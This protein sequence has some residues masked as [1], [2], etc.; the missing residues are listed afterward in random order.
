M[1]TGRT[2]A[3][4]LS[5]AT[6]YTIR[7]PQGEAWRPELAY[8]FM[9][10]MAQ[11]GRMLFRI[12]ADYSAIRFQIV[13]VREDASDDMVK[14]AVLATYPQAEVEAEPLA[15][16]PFVKPFHRWIVLF[17]QGV[18][19]VAPIRYPVELKDYDPLVSLTNL[20]GELQPDEYVSYLCYVGKHDPKLRDEAKKILERPDWQIWATGM[21]GAAFDMN[22]WMPKERFTPELQKIFYRKLNDVLYPTY[23]IAQIDTPSYER[24]LSLGSGIEN[25]LYEMS[26]ELQGIVFYDTDQ[27]THEINSEAD[28][29]RHSALSLLLAWSQGTN[30]LYKHVRCVFNVSEL[31]TLWHLPHEDFI[32]PTIARIS[33]RRVRIPAILRDKREGICL[34]D[35]VYAGTN[36]PVYMR[37]EDRSTHMIVVGR[38]GVG[39]STFL[40]NLIEQDIAAGSGVAVLDPHGDLIRDILHCSIPENRMDDVVLWDLADMQN[41]PPLNLLAIPKGV[42]RDK[43][44][45]QVMA[46]FEKVEEG[47][48]ATRM[49]ADLSM[50]LELLMAEPNPTLRDVRKVFVDEQYRAKLMEELENDIA[51]EFWEDFDNLS[52]R[53]QQTRSAPI[54]TRVQRLYKNQTL[55][56]IICHPDPLD[57]SALI[58]QN[59]II[60][61]SLQQTEQSMLDEREVELLGAFMISQF[62]MAV[63]ARAATQPFYLYV[64][65]AQRFTTTAIDR[66][67]AEARKRKLALI[68]ANQHLGQLEGK[69]LEAV[70]ENVGAMVFFQCG[71]RN[72][73]MIAPYMRPSFSV[74]DMVQLD[75]HQ[76]GVVMR[77]KGAQLPAFSLQ[78]RPAPLPDIDAIPV[79]LE[80]RIREL[81]RSKYTQK[82]AAEVLEW[83]DHRYPR[84]K[85]RKKEAASEEFTEEL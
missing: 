55:Y 71:E 6:V 17:R 78:T 44:A 29:Q 3:Q 27:T 13:D 82:T 64:D 51:Y 22:L 83:L 35:N 84:S 25:T 59:K 8:S 81:S 61:I 31:A 30:D 46:V 50:A 73:H 34:G 65:E 69:T 66:I 24:F 39:K 58:A 72:A 67:F 63:M 40:H 75:L 11:S 5:S 12:A 54:L 2:L 18:N 77:Y 38:T 42:E 7:L 79:G 47:F 1:Q 9:L 70:M 62:Q 85:G 37:H 19:F 32:A 52:L 41:P 14:G 48:G 4:S 36:T 56:P 53:E 33:G 60:L 10:R 45:A 26:S 49:A 68:L 76:A 16:R 57:F 74:E 15:E 20:I 43:A 21:A 28:M 23:L 80:N